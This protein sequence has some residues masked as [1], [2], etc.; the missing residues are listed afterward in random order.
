MTPTQVAIGLAL[1]SLASGG[2]LIRPTPTRLRALALLP[3]VSH[4]PTWLGS[5]FSELGHWLKSVITGGGAIVLAAIAGALFASAK[6]SADVLESLRLLIWAL[7]LGGAA[8]VG[9]WSIR[10]GVRLQRLNLVHAEIALPPRSAFESALLSG[11]AGSSGSMAVVLW[12][13]QLQ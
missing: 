4:E 11:L 3:P 7:A 6:Q 5:E 13:G 10:F 1:A 9:V 12:L 2:F 8:M